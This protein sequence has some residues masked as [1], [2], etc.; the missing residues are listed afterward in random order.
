V[1]LQVALEVLDG[2]PNEYDT[3]LGDNGVRLSG[4]QKQRVAIAR[5]LLKDADFLV[6]DEATS[7]LDSHLEADVHRGIETMERDYGV[8]AIAHRL[9][10]ITDADRIYVM[11]HGFIVES[12]DH[13]SLAAHGGTYANLL[14]TQSHTV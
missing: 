13:S 6:L 8:I 1:S 2:L 5:A 11:E 7:N 10:T 12:G 3:V 4:G 14:E 9:S